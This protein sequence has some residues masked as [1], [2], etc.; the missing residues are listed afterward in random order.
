MFCKHCG[1]PIADGAAFC[2]KCGAPVAATSTPNVSKAPA[3][4]ADDPASAAPAAPAQAAPSSATRAPRRRTRTAIIA[5]AAVILLALCGIGGFWWYRTSQQ[6]SDQAARAARK[7]T[8]TLTAKGFDTS[9]GSKLPIH[10][11]GSNAQG[12]VDEVQFVDDAGKGITLAG[13]SY[14]MSF[15]ASPIAA[16]GTLY[17]LPTQAIDLE[18]P[19]SEQTG[20]DATVKNDPIALTPIE[21]ATT[22]TDTQIEAAKS[23]A[24][25]KGACAHGVDAGKLGEAVT[26]KRSNAQNAKNSAGQAQ[27]QT[28]SNNQSQSQGQSQGSNQ[29]QSQ[30]K[31]G[32]SRDSAG[33]YHVRTRYYTFDLPSYWNRTS[34]NVSVDGDITTVT[35]KLYPKLV[36]CRVLVTQNGVNSEDCGGTFY[37]NESNNKP[38]GDGGYVCVYFRDYGKYIARALKANTT[39]PEKQFTEAEANDAIKLQTGGTHAYKEY[40]NDSSLLEDP[41]SYTMG[42]S[43]RT[44]NA[45]KQLLA[46]CIKVL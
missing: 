16:D 14:K 25:K 1:A 39:D 19:E 33:N 10:I 4:S 6:G 46:G 28:P 31:L 3:P 15:P 24:S 35:S 29:S 30:G 20:K 13:G 17:Q 27:S 41:G 32:I 23:Y 2:T 22:Y 36:I 45:M 42:A 26:L 21:D 40:I 5:A 12:S 34:V 44:S 11:T 7:V 18:V 37:P 43:D 8:L 38:V 9:T